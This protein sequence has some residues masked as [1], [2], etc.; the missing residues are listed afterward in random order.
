MNTYLDVAAIMNAQLRPAPVTKSRIA[1]TKDQKKQLRAWYS[2]HAKPPGHTAAAAWFQTRFKVRI[3]QSTISK[4]LSA[5]YKYLDS[6]DGLNGNAIRNTKSRWPDLEEVLFT[7]YQVLQ[8]RGCSF[9]QEEIIAKAQ[10][11][12]PQLY[13]NVTPPAFSNGW[14]HRFRDRCKKRTG[15]VGGVSE[16]TGGLPEEAGSLPEEVGEVPEETEVE[17]QEVRGNVFEDTLLRF[18][19]N[20]GG[21]E[22]EEEDEDEDDGYGPWNQPPTPTIHEAIASLKTVQHWYETQPESTFEGM[23][24]INTLMR[25]MEACKA[26]SAVKK[27]LNTTSVLK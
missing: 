7:W 13:P 27:T 12:W 15:K 17:M 14:I 21:E 4:A 8:A 26:R 16:G 9:S 3:Q 1:I 25:Q 23:K 19:Q 18:A 10:I 5:Q 2:A 6:E 11:A 20:E 22:E 24:Q